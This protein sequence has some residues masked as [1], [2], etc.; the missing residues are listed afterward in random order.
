MSSNILKFA[1]TSIFCM[2]WGACIFLA[3]DRDHCPVG[4]SWIEDAGLALAGPLDVYV[5]SL[6]WSMASFLTIGCVC[7]RFVNVGV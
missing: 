3:L 6:Y 5:A 1:L 4:H 7:L 2:H